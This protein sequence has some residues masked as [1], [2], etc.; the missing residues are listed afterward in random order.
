[1]LGI[2]RLYL[3]KYNLIFVKSNK[4]LGYI[5]FFLGIHFLIVFHK[6][7]SHVQH[8]CND[9]GGREKTHSYTGKRESER[10]HMELSDILEALH[11]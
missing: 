9:F 10:G 1:M 7:M 3:L 5:S 2:V 8:S 6:G 11:V 4:N